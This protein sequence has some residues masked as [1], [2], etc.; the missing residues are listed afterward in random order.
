MAARKA[1]DDKAKAD[2]S[3]Q[4]K[5]V[6][7]DWTN[8]IKALVRSRANVPETVTGKPVVQVRL[9]LL[10]N[11]V[12]FEGQLAR[13]S[14]NRAYDEAVERAIAGIREW[15]TPTDPD[16][17]RDNREIILNIEYEK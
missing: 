5:K 17:F 7:D 3:A 1:A 15:P 10:V 2:A 13:A 8:R 14:G 6:V 9:R 4:K 11:G 12:V 16:V